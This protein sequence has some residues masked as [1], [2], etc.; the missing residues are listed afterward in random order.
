MEMFDVVDA[1]GNPTG[2]VVERAQAHAE[3]IRH[4]TAHVWIL[5]QAHGSIQIL[6][7]RRSPDKDS[8]P[9]C[10]DI[11]SAGHV[12]AGA[13]YIPS[14]LRELEEELGVAADAQ[15][16]HYCGQR[17]FTFRQEFHGALFQDCQVSRIYI[18]WLDAEETEFHLQTEE[19]EEVRWFD[20]AEALRLVQENAIPHCIYQEEL[21][22]V[23][24]HME[25][26]CSI[27]PIEAGDNAR[28]KAI[29]QG[30]LKEHGLAIPGT[31]YF[32]PQLSALSEYYRDREHAAYW[33]LEYD[34]EVIGGA[35]VAPFEGRP[36]TGEL[37]KF[38]LNRAFR[39]NGFGRRL[40]EQ[41]VSFGRQHFPAL[42]IETSDVL[43]AANQI[44]LR[45]G[46]RQLEAPFPGTAH[47][48]MN[49]WYLLEFGGD[50]RAAEGNDSDV[51]G[52]LHN[53]SGLR[54][55]HF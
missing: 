42:Y 53:D 35:G 26:S 2:R 52:G 48:A 32:D 31:A 24:Q 54:S 17:H 22:M 55:A 7:Q 49:R 15:Q 40:M 33:V 12:P 25:I 19:V 9:G 11:S 36:E 28:M 16:L 23:E 3:G 20:F 1:Q 45:Y 8:Y 46:F 10:Y 37:Q 30:S 5:R 34:G 51:Q 43:A 4:R 29:L 18:L 14:A 27:R 6:L 13:D 50:G 44:Y 21:R 41:A 38:Y 39:G 47:T